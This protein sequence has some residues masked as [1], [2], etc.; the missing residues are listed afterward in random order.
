MD[1]T[2]SVPGLVL[3]AALVL[4]AQDPQQAIEAAAEKQRASVAAMSASLEKQKA[5]VRRQVQAPDTDSFFITPLP[6]V[7]VEAQAWV[8]PECSPLSRNEASPLIEKNA[9]A[10]GL[11][12]SVIWAVM[13]QESAYYP[14]L[15]R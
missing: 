2:Q 7:V 12:P 15:R 6:P 3:L 5:S 8:P 10:T 11:M 4:K 14:E 13:E 9:A 1:M